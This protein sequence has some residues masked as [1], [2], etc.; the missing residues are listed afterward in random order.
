MKTLLAVM[1]LLGLAA[2]SLALYLLPVLIGRIRHAPDLGMVAVINLFLG[3][4]FIGWV[5]A[6]ALALRSAPPAAP[7]VHVANYL[8]PSPPAIPPEDRPWTG[9]PG[10]PYRTE[11]P[12]PLVLPPRSAAWPNVPGW[13]PWEAPWDDQEP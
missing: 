4:T 8:Q 11:P 13:S 7:F 10:T 2:V 6:L 3:W 9:H 1:V 12:P 5:I